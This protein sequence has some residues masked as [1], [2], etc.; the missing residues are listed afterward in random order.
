MKSQLWVPLRV[1]KL[2]NSILIFFKFERKKFCPGAE[3]EPEPL[4]LRANAY[5]LS[6]PGQVRVHDRINLLE[7]FFLTSGPTY[8]VFIMSYGGMHSQNL[9]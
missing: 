4:A 3:L 1:I 7:P 6:Y 8:C 2:I 5:Q 9:E